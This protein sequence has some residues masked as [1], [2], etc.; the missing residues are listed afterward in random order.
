MHRNKKLGFLRA[1]QTQY[2]LTKA[3]YGNYN[4]QVKKLGG[5]SAYE[6]LYNT[7]NNITVRTSTQLNKISDIC[8]SL[9]GFK[10]IYVE[11]NILSYSSSN[12]NNWYKSGIISGTTQ[13][14]AENTFFNPAI[15]FND[16]IAIIR[17][18]GAGSG[19]MTYSISSTSTDASHYGYMLYIYVNSGNV[20]IS[21]SINIY[22]A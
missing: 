21:Y 8:S 14:K 22:T 4:N 20:S 7:S 6:V 3:W 17:S 19:S 13:Y 10:F 9:N 5:S 12:T 11:L 2:G 16:N 1:G 18:S 15:C